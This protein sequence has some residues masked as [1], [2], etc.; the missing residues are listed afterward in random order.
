MWYSFITSTYPTE[1]IPD[2]NTNMNDFQMNSQKI[3]DIFNLNFYSLDIIISE[4]KAMQGTDEQISKLYRI[5]LKVPANLWSQQVLTVR[6]DMPINNFEIKALQSY[7]LRNRM[8]LNLISTL[9]NNKIEVEHIVKL[10]SL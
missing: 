7:A 8:K 4:I 1:V 5:Q 10:S 6:N 9:I 2:Y 3:L